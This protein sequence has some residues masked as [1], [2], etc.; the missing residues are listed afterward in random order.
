[1]T[2]PEETEP[3]P[4][5]EERVAAMEANLAGWE[6]WRAQAVARFT[7]VETLVAQGATRLAQIEA[8]VSPVLSRLIA[9]EAAGAGLQSALDGLQTFAATVNAG[10]AD[11]NTR[12]DALGRIARPGRTV[13]R[14]QVDQ[15]LADVE[16]LKAG[17]TPEGG[18][19]TP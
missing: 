13:I 16:T 2:G 5:I 19:E 1:M 9:L 12:F 8:N 15:L 17:Q 7:A 10:L 3:T 4:S 18:G 11:L 14:G 6:E